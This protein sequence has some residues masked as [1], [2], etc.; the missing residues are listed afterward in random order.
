MRL[1]RERDGAVIAK[2]LEVA[3]SFGSRFLGL[4]GRAS[5]PSGGALWIEPCSS[6]H[7]M[8]MR[9]RID[10]VFVDSDTRVLKV[11]PRVLPWLGFAFCHGANAVI[12]LEAGAAAKSNLQQGDILKRLELTESHA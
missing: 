7:M 6:I 3:A 8:F 11:S 1:V 9:F 4:M 10:A 5:L 2:S 12:E